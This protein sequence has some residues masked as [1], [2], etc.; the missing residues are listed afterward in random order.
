MKRNYNKA[1]RSYLLKNKDTIL[2]T[3]IFLVLGIPATILVQSNMLASRGENYQLFLMFLL[4]FGIS[5]MQGSSMV[6][7]LTVKDRLSRRL[8]FYLA[9]GGD[10]KEILK[11]YSLEMFRIAA[12]I[13]FFIF[14]ACF[15]MIDWT[16]PFMK[17]IF[18]YLTTSLVAYL[19]IYFLNTLVLSIKRFKL[20]KNVIFFANFFTIFLL[21]NLGP[22]LLDSDIFYV[23]SLDTVIICFNLIIGL[24]LL[25]IIL[26]KIKR[27]NNEDII[28]RDALWE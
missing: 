17:M 6:V 24:L 20:F 15:Y 28:R 11:A 27:L 22:S 12:V 5:F 9:S 2:N 14:M 10:I 1:A 18:I 4:I 3:I 23:L 21:T 19:G 16:V 13:P 26:V 7:D 25:M 8:E